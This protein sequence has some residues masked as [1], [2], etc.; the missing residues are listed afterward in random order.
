MKCTSFAEIGGVAKGLS[1]IVAITP[2]VIIMKSTSIVSESWGAYNGPINNIRFDKRKT[3]SSRSPVSC[4]P[5][6]EQMNP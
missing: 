1:C 2:I 6:P 3:R 5:M 4:K